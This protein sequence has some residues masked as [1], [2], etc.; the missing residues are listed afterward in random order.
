MIV[1][2]D[3]L[4]KDSCRPECFRNVVETSTNLITTLRLYIEGHVT[5]K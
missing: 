4:L 2:E 5:L 3:Y 1:S